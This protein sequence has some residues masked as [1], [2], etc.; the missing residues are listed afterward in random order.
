MSNGVWK[1]RPAGCPSK[2]SEMMIDAPARIC[3]IPIVA[4]A[5]MSRGAWRKRR[6]T[7]R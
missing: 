2:M 5:R 6:I 3:A 4:T 1:P 7:K